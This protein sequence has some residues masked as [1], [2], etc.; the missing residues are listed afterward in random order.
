MT[1]ASVA[2]GRP[3][4]SGVSQ[5]IVNQEDE[6]DEPVERGSH[7][8]GV[9]DRAAGEARVGRESLHE[10]GEDVPSAEC[11][12]FLVGVDL[13]AAA[14]GE[15]AGGADRFRVGDQAEREPAS[16]D[17]ADVLEADVREREGGERRGQVHHD[18]DPVLGQ[19]ERTACSDAR[20]DDDQRGG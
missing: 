15:R 10:A 1:A 17:E 13:V 4:K 12:Q 8:R 16:E 19:V 3:S 14:S 20:A 2:C 7:S 18:R 11:D 6:D 5:R 9:G